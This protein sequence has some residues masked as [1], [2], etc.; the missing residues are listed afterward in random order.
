MWAAVKR[1]LALF[2]FCHKTDIMLD[3]M[4]L[5]PA[6]HLQPLLPR[7]DGCVFKEKGEGVWG[8]DMEPLCCWPR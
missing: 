5:K 2:C 1:G 7:S 8:G 3:G 6:S 4:T